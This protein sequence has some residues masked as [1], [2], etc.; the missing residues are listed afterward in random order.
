MKK[1]EEHRS[2]ARLLDILELVAS[3]ND[4]GFTLTEIANLIGAPKGSIFPIVHTLNRRRYLSVN[5]YT[6]KYTIGIGT[7]AVG[8]AFLDS[9]TVYTHIKTIMNEVVNSCGEICQMGIIDKG[10]VLYVA[11]VDSSESVRL[12][13]YIGKRL[14]LYATALGK[15]LI[16]N[17]T[18]SDLDKL[19]PDVNKL[20]KLTDNTITDLDILYE[21]LNKFKT[22]GVVLESQESDTGIKCYAVPLVQ[23]GKIVA[24]ISVSVPIFRYTDEKS[25][26]ILDSLVLAKSSIEKILEDIDPEIN[27]LQF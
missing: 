17:Y 23:H 12:I 18:R 27:F 16:L 25:N 11:K 8:S 15:A 3:S 6:G 13:S 24:A 7:F 9:K 14:P 10:K 1:F 22:S 5:P 4:E 19:Y 20:E 21:Q 26:I 2:S